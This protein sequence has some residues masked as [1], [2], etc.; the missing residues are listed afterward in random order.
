MVGNAR[1]HDE[2]KL[3]V[4]ATAANARIARIAG[5]GLATRLGFSP[6]EA[7]EVRM[8]VGEAW[9]IL[10]GSRD[11]EGTVHLT[12]CT[13]EE[14]MVIE[15]QADVPRVRRTAPDRTAVAERFLAR[16]VDD[17]DVSPD[18]TVVRLHKRHHAA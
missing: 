4:P 3:T 12:F 10:L 15:I 13:E 16:V 14:G 5:V 18:R 11:H 6:S 1:E 9:A 2:I 7:E 17:L 8:A